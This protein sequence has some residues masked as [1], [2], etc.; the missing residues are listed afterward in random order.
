MSTK[1]PIAVK[2]CGITQV[3][4]A[5]KIASLG[6]DA[7]GVIGVKASPRF[8]AEIKRRELFQRLIQFNPLIERVWVV[9]DLEIQEIM[10]GIKGEG[11]PSVIQLHGSE[12]KR[13]CKEL[14]QLSPQIKLWKS[15]QIRNQDDLHLAKE[16]EYLVDAILLDAWSSEALGG[17]GN[18]IPLDL[19]NTINFQKPWWIAGGISSDYI[20]EI[21]FSI[22][23][24]GIDASSK[25]ETKPGIKDIQKVERLLKKINL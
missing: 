13:F 23:P 1:A 7:I 22:K 24:Y 3:K 17:T 21:L 10:Q 16:Y 19:L 9:A 15:F 20:E 12:S 18:R 14:H 11:A 2:I 6:V 4:Q 5:L 8:L 25:L